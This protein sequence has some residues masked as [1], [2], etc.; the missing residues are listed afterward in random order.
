[1]TKRVSIDTIRWNVPP[2]VQELLKR[3]NTFVHVPI[4]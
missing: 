4:R 1:M 3:E 2:S